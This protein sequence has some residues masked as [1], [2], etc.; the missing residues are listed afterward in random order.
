MSDDPCECVVKVT[1]QGL[2]PAVE[3]VVLRVNLI[4]APRGRVR[5]EE[6]AGFLGAY[7]AVSRGLD[8]R[9]GKRTEAFDRGISLQAALVID[10]EFRGTSCRIR[11]REMVRFAGESHWSLAKNR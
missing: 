6:S 3:C 8:K 7:V 10:L 5:P 2:V 4:Q 9:E 1:Q 11:F